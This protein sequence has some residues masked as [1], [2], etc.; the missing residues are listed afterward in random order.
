VLPF[1]AAFRD[2]Q[3]IFDGG[4]AVCETALA[5]QD[6]TARTVA[7]QRVQRAARGNGAAKVAVVVGALVRLVR[8]V[9]WDTVFI[10]VSCRFFMSAGHF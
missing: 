5:V 7:G 3:R 4:G 1:V 6:N 10:A 2:S 9:C 8:N